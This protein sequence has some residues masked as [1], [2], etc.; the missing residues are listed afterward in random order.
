MLTRRA[1]QHLAKERRDEFCKE[2]VGWL[3]GESR[4]AN[5]SREGRSENPAVRTNHV[6]DPRGA[7]MY[8]TTVGTYSFLSV[9]RSPVQVPPGC[10]TGARASFARA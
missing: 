8:I 6:K 4:S 7:P 2:C 10:G 5:Q 3:N 1:R 9:D